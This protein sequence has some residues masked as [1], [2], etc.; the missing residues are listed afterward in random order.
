MGLQKPKKRFFKY[1]KSKLIV[2]Y[3]DNIHSIFSNSLERTRMQ[4][5]AGIAEPF[6]DNADLYKR[7]DAAVKYIKLYKEKPVKKEDTNKEAFIKILTD[8]KQQGTNIAE[9]S[10]TVE[11][12]KA[13][14]ELGEDAKDKLEKYRS[15]PTP[16]ISPEEEMKLFQRFIESGKK[17]KQTK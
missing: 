7:Y 13:L 8:A 5:I 16:D 11:Q 4:V 14:W 3:Y 15:E 2:F 12:K 6:Q 9:T 17:A 10:K 1:I